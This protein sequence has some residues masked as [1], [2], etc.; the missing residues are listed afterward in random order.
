MKDNLYAVLLAGG[1]GTRLWP[2]STGEL[3]KS[4]I[5][6]GNRRILMQE[7]LDRLRGIVERQATVIV[8]DRQKKK[9]LSNFIKGIPKKNVLIEPVGRN[10]AAA[11]GL[12]AI[13]LKSEDIMLVLPVDQFVEGVVD[14]KS[15]V[16]EGARF[17]EKNHNSLICLATRPRHA[18]ESFGY[19]KVKSRAKGRIFLVDK[20]IE[21]P[22]LIKAV[23]FQK[24]PAYLWNSGMFMFKSKTILRAM[25]SYAPALYRNL[26]KIK[27]RP[28][29]IGSIYSR[30]KSVSLDY[31]V[32]E[33]AG[34][35]Y[36][37]KGRFKW[38]DIG[39]WTSLEKLI[40]G[41]SIKKNVCVG[42][43][44]T[45]DVSDSFIYNAGEK[46]V[47][48]I[49]LTGVIIVNT[50]NGVLVCAKKDVERVRELVKRMRI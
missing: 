35:V 6:L 38:H 3:S 11:V 16:K 4:F 27:K 45:L 25:K 41:N 49:G 14:F 31:Q 9:L 2:L 18:S 44:E 29:S 5:R 19:L 26:M 8:I 48:A 20:F 33:K 37:I 40:S 30:F 46:P 32:M 10:T 7:V 24:D 15:V 1:K 12:A 34:D 39:K 42:K 21:K 47:G 22:S 28:N 23:Q 17:I 36:C 50:D 13:N 43:T